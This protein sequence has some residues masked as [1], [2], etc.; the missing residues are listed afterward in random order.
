MKYIFGPVPS[1]RLGWSLG[2]DI[3]PYKTC[4]YDCIYC[5]LGSTTCLTTQPVGLIDPGAVLAEL[6]VFLATH[7]ERIDFLTLSGSGEPTLHP[8]LGYLIRA[9]KRRYALSVALITN[10]SLLFRPEVLERVRAADLIIPSLDAVDPPT[11]A[12]VNRP[13]PDLDLDSLRAG[14]LALGHLPGPRIWLE[15]LFIEGIN[16]HPD[17]VEGYKQIIEKINPERVQINTIVRPPAEAWA[18]P[19]ETHRLDQIREKL[20][21]RA[22][23]IA[24]PDRN[25]HR[26]IRLEDEIIQLVSRRPCTAEDIAQLTGR[27]SNETLAL[28]QR[29]IGEGRIMPAPFDREMYYRRRTPDA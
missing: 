28:L 3:L 10:S 24:R 27:P 23:I 25:N 22:E 12:A 6:D 20:G 26:S 9:L 15:L 17:Q 16:D 29:L 14:L 4:S 21:P 18:L 13:H 2:L 19:L 7:S 1:R 11:L 5:E 8:E